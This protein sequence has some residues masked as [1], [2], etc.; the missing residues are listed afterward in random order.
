MNI[1][2]IKPHVVSNDLTGKSFLI[3]GERKVGKTTCASHFPKS[4]I[5]GFE[6]GWNE[7]EGVIAFPINSWREALE[8]KRDLI[9]DAEEVAEKK[10]RGEDAETFYKTVI[11]D[12]A[13][14]AYD[15]CEKY[16]LD[17][18]GVEYLDETEKLRGYRAVS[19]EFDKFFQEI[20]KAGYTLV[21]ISH[22]TSKQIKA[23]GEKYEKTIPTIPDRGFLVISRLVDIIAY[24]TFEENPQ[25]PENPQR[26]LF[27][28]GNKY[29]EAGSR[30]KYTSICIP[31][32]YEALRDDMN[33]AFNRMKE[34]GG[35]VT[36]EANNLFKQE[37]ED[38][39][40]NSLVLEIKK[41]AVALH[42]LDKTSDY[43]KIV[44]EYLGKG[45]NVK[46]CTESQTD[47]LILILAEL[48]DYA[49]KN[50]IE[51]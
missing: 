5:F 19:R 12:T 10:A 31:F 45:R 1:F 36:E 33:N 30:N 15:M 18:E 43:N 39:D 32:T 9:N 40:F 41:Y 17:K 8:A 6:K 25:D 3:Y 26:I 38:V 35:N 13:D 22:A 44:A 11:I 14:L 4:I 28:R 27:L 51:V 16:I 20:V 48:K 47:M 42:N 2:Q 37:E 21:C 24:A 29:L 50:S 49:K 34:E 46:E 23:N 7:L